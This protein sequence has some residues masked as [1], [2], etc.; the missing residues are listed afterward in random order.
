[1]HKYFAPLCFLL[2]LSCSDDKEVSPELPNEIAITDQILALVN[3]H[4]QGIGLSSLSKN[5]TAEEL[6][7]EHTQYMIGRSQISHD[8][9]E[10]RSDE[11][12][13]LEN[14]VATGENVAAGQTSATAVMNAWLNSVTHKE[15]IEGNFTH[16]GIAAIQN[17]NGTYYYTQLFL[18][19]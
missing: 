16:I 19:K 2:V 10:N 14:A 18:R 17:T 3:E 6:A 5:T 9:F 1:M 12:G 13:E 15:N 4:R 7:I 8:G 11:L